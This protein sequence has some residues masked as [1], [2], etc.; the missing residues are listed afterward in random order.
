MSID[1]TTLGLQALNFL[2]LAW[3]LH[4]FLYKPV[5]GV[6]ARRKAEIAGALAQG[7]DAERRA[8][9]AHASWETRRTAL[10]KER[11]R[12]VEDTRR[13]LDDERSALLTTARSDAEAILAGARRHIAEERADALAEL[14]QHAASLAA[15]MAGRLLR[16]YP[17]P[18]LAEG[19]VEELVRHLEA[20]PAGEAGRLRTQ[21][22]DGR[23]ARLRTAPALAPEAAARW[24][25]RL[26]AWLGNGARVEIETDE[27]LIAGAELVLPHAAVRS[28]WRDALEAMSEV[29]RD[30]AA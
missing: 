9:E 8:E 19:F 13:Q 17:T 24:R 20:L 30:H 29:G 22:A 6:M 12:M 5:L 21:A 3:L 2:V 10:A 18:A 25:G 11:E 7:A 26:E 14:Q 23:R 16:R 15:D 27:A 1:W 28:S 4:R